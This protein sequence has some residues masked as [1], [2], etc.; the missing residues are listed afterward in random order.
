MS[1]KSFLAESKF[2]KLTPAEW[3]KYDWRVDVFL[4]KY[5]E[6][7]EF[8][9][10]DGKKV[11]FEYSREVERQ[12]KAKDF[13]K[14]VLTDKD[15]NAYKLSQ[16]G[17]TPEFGGKGEGASTSK[18]DRELASLRNQLNELKSK[19]A[20]STVPIKIGKKVYHVFDAVTTPGVPKS[21]FHLVDID[22]NEIVWISHKDGSKPSDFQQWSGISNRKEPDIF[23]HPETKSFIEDLKAM[24]PDGLPRATSLYRKITDEKLKMLAVYG[25]QYKKSLGQQNVSILIQGPVKLI[26]SGSSYKFTSNHIHFN[27]DKITGDFEPVLCAIYKGDRSDAG[28]KGT[29]IVIMPIKGR[30]MKG[31][32]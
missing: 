22:G 18:E 19:L 27:G 14:V 15:G 11:K 8:Y 24:Y 31:T 7:D 20:S 25:N 3:R 4:K 13:N 2:T 5:K 16:L 32:I 17:K 30:K 26:R 21:D 9:L 12:M 10:A 6:Q 23:N 28:V 1:L 29:R